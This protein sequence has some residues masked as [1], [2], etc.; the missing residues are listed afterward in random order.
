MAGLHCNY[1][2]NKI[3]YQTRAKKRLK[4]PSMTCPHCFEE[5]TLNPGLLNLA[6]LTF[7]VTVSFVLAALVYDFLRDFAFD[8]VLTFYIGMVP[9][10]IYPLIAIFLVRV[11]PD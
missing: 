9:L 4:E 8:P 5:N 10:L 3:P 6:K 2:E 7:Y 11:E 1:C